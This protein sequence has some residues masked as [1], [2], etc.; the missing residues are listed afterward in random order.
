MPNISLKYEN[1]LFDCDTPFNEQFIANVTADT[2]S[3]GLGEDWKQ[4][5]YASK[6]SMTGSFTTG[7]IGSKAIQTIDMSYATQVKF[8]IKS[9]RNLSSGDLQ[10][11]LDNSA[12]CASPVETL[13]IPELTANT[14]AEVTLTL[15]NPSLDTAIRSIGL[16]RTASL[17]LS[18]TVYIDDIRLT[19]DA[20]TFNALSVRGAD[21]PDEIRFFPRRK[22]EL[23]E[24]TYHW[25][26]RAFSR[27]ITIRLGVVQSK[28]DRLFLLRWLIGN[29][30]QITYAGED[31]AVVPEDTEGYE[32]EWLDGVE[33]ARDYTIRANETAVRLPHNLPTSW[34]A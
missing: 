17:G 10:F 6:F 13:D 27:V 22:T 1:R 30:R 19:D 24:G 31:I 29:D 28:D 5:S 11:L 16:K 23:I 2:T 21:A 20:R 8:W 26:A 18:H 4:G 14:W 9:D 15:D 32:N 12:N 34:I 33:F 3:L 7:L 25:R